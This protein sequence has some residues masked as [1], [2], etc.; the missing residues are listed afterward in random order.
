MIRRNGC[1]G[2]WCVFG[3]GEITE[4]VGHC[5]LEGLLYCVAKKREMDPSNRYLYMLNA[6][7]INTYTDA[8]YT[9]NLNRDEKVWSNS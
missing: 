9:S 7:R 4:Q 1:F 2:S 6:V 5:G 8:L 3:G